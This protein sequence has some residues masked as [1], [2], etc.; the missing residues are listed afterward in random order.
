MKYVKVAAKPP[1]WKWRLAATTLLVLLF[2]AAQVE[3]NMARQDLT[4]DAAKQL[5]DDAAAYDA[6]RLASTVDVGTYAAI[7]VGMGLFGLWGTY[8]YQRVRY[9]QIEDDSAIG[10]VTG[11]Y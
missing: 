5:Q 3:M 8:A 4:A 10:E 11:T 7:L 9:A 1:G 6:A 2:G